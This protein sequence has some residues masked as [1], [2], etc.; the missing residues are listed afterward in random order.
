MPTMSAHAPNAALPAAHSSHII[1]NMSFHGCGLAPLATPA[2]GL[3]SWFPPVSP[4]SH[5]SAACPLRGLALFSPSG[6]VRSGCAALHR[7]CRGGSPRSSSLP[8]QCLA[9]VPVT[10]G[11][12]ARHTGTSCP[13]PAPARLPAAHAPGKPPR[14]PDRPP[15]CAL[16]GGCSPPSRWAGP[17][18]VF[19]SIGGLRPVSSSVARVRP[20]AGRPSPTRLAAY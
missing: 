15:L 5:V 3:R 12:R 2:A 11:L 1:F 18:G 13:F 9:T 19:H 17:L 14:V 4:L 7:A 10:P 20:Q 16:P 6:T 8:P